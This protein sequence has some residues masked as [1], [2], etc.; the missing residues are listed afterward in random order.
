MKRKSD[1]ITNSSSTNYIVIETW[2][3]V[4]GDI[5]IYKDKD[6]M[7][8]INITK[9][10]IDFVNDL[11]YYDE[12]WMIDFSLVVNKDHLQLS[13]DGEDED[14]YSEMTIGDG[15]N[16]IEVGNFDLTLN[17]YNNKSWECSV[18]YSCD[19]SSKELDKA[20][21]Q[22]ITKFIKIFNFNGSIEI[23]IERR[24]IECP[25]DGWDG[26]DPMGYYA[27]SEVCKKEV[28]CKKIITLNKGE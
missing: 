17:S 7:E 1:F 27:E 21:N 24:V 19:R 22:L 12:D 15:D 14:N 8:S 26:G 9:Q 2:E 16:R 13:I 18:H 3:V 10:F 6:K 5:K 23:G 28:N 25:T 4:S 20:I 11:T